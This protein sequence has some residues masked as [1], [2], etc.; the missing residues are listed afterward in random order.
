MESHKPL[1]NPA[2]YV[3]SQTS[4]PT[5]W[6]DQLSELYDDLVKVSGYNDV[7]RRKIASSQLLSDK[8]DNE[9]IW[10]QIELLN[11]AFSCDIEIGLNRKNDTG[12]VEKIIEEEEF[13]HDFVPDLKKEVECTGDQDEESAIDITEMDSFCD[14][15]EIEND[16]NF[17][18]SDTIFE[19]E[20]EESALEKNLRKVILVLF[21]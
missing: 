10:Q 5:V 6:K 15:A 11:E 12:K 17:L 21:V 19:E 1:M 8:F 20:G 16:G 7:L 13:V 3:C 14:A 18:L 4:T 9:Q 2:L